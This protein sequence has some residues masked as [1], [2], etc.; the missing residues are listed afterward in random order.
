MCILA[1]SQTVKVKR[2]RAFSFPQRDA[3]RSLGKQFQAEKLS[4]ITAHVF[5]TGAVVLTGAC[6]AELARL[7]A[8]SLTAYFNKFLN[9]QASVAV[10]TIRNIVSSYA[11]I[12]SRGSCRFFT[13]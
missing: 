7:A 11:A 5:A 1:C 12:F 3:H 8:W 13:L 4:E 10:F 9:I 6:H 2:S